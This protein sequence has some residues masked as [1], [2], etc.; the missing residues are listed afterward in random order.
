[1]FSKQF[2]GIA[3]ISKSRT[4]YFLHLMVIKCLLVLIVLSSEDGIVT[5]TG[6]AIVYHPGSSRLVGK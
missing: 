5:G 2:Y 1:M 4:F 6:V 3:Q